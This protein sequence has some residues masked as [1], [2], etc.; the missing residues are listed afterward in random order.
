MKKIVF[1]IMML[2]V[3]TVATKAQEMN[4]TV[5]GNNATLLQPAKG[6]IYYGSE[7][8]DKKDCVEFLSTRHKPSYETFKS[9]YKCYSAGWWTLGA[10]LAVDLAGSLIFAF[11]PEEGNTAMFYSGMTCLVL[12]A[13]GIIASIPTIYIGYGRMNKG[14]DMFNRAQ[15]QSTP[16]A[17]WTIQGSQNGVVLAMHF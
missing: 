4:A 11:A 14:I 7:V 6:W 5:V 1:L 15:V 17:Y 8:M 3:A 16:Q 13:A 9:G 2:V 10:G 12:G